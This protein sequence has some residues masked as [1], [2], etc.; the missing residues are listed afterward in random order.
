MKEIALQ[1][2]Y[3]GGEIVETIYFGGGTPSLLEPAELRSLLDALYHHFPVS[4]SPEITLECNP[5]DVAAATL[6]TWSRL[7]INRLSLGIQSFFEEDLRWMNRAHTAEQAL[8]ALDL[9]LAY[10][11]NTTAD[12]IYGTPYLTDGKWEANVNR[13]LDRKMPH[14]SCYA[15][16]VEP[17]TLLHKKI[18]KGQSPDVDPDR[19]A[20][21]FLLLM[22]WLSKAGYEHYEIS[23]FARPGFRSRHNG[24]YWEGKKYLGLGPS[25]HSFDGTSRQWNPAHN[26]QYIEALEK[27]MLPFEKEILSP[28]QQVNEYIMTGLRTIEGLDLNRIPALYRDSIRAESMTYQ[29]SGHLV[30]RDEK[31]LL[32]QTGKLLADG[33]ASD[34]FRDQ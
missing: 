3:L 12:L 22:D 28:V 25:A 26:G 1:K 6:E 9:V 19:Q 29:Q 34:L 10:F 5:D 15:L 27:G 11:P 20:R 18:S 23:N 4:A 24:S 7:G 21:Q 17:Q 8:Q 30:L 13:M 16:T 31:L 32:T 33:I 14:L 2:D